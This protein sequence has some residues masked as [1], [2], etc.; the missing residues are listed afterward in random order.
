MEVFA[1]EDERGEAERGS[2]ALEEDMARM[3]GDMATLSVQVG[4]RVLKA[5][6]S[7]LMRGYAARRASAH[8]QS[9]VRAKACETRSLA[10]ASKTA[11]SW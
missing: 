7:T 5:R 6:H 9:A 3:G 8:S 2:S 10:V 1:R 4:F 11:L